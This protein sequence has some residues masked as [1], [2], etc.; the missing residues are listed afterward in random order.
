MKMYDITNPTYNYEY[1][2]T[3]FRQNNIDFSAEGSNIV[4]SKE[5]FDNN[6]NIADKFYLNYNIVNG[7][8][9]L[10]P[11]N[12]NDAINVFISRFDEYELTEWKHD[13]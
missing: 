12:I 6:P 2:L 8:V 13:N 11:M 1:L 4:L 10:S 9:Y 7:K 3:I 5:T